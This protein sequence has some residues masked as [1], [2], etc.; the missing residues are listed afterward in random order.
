MMSARVAPLPRLWQCAPMRRGT[1]K[2]GG[3][4]LTLGILL[5]LVAGV[6]A[7]NAMA[8]VLFGT[9]AGLALAVVTWLL[10]RRRPS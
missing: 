7:G 10:D 2:A 8:G 3:F 6:I 1:S 4:F 9:L 5:G